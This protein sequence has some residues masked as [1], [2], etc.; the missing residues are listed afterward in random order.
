MKMKLNP[1]LR[2][3]LYY[4]AGI[5]LMKSAAL[6]TLPIVTAHLTPE[7]YGSLEILVTLADLGG[8]L[9]G[10]GMVEALFRFAG[11]AQDAAER[12]AVAASI[13]GMALT[14]AA[15]ALVATQATA[16][17][18]TSLLP[19]VGLETVQVRWLLLTLVLT[20]CIQ[21]PLAWLRMSDRAG[22]FFLATLAKT[23][24]QTCLVV[25]TVRSGYGVTGIVA[26]NA[27]ADILLATVL[28]CT[29]ARDSGLRFVGRG[30]LRYVTYSWPLIFSGLALF[31]VGSFDRWILAD[32]VSTREIAFY[33]L[34]CKFALI[35]A[36]LIRPFEMW[37]FPRRFQVLNAAQGLE[38]SARVASAGI[39]YIVLVTTSVAMFGP[40]LVLLLLPP[41]YHE[42]I[43]YLPWVTLAAGLQCATSLLTVGCYAGKTTL[44]PMGINIAGAAVAF[45]GYVV[46]IPRFGIMGA[47]AAT[48]CAQCLRLGL[49]HTLSQKAVF[50]PYPNARLLGLSFVA[51]VAVLVHPPEL[52]LHSLTSGLAVLLA[53]LT[54]S[55]SLRL[56]PSPRAALRRA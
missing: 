14:F 41:D 38:S 36:L 1:V 23:V 32:S 44:L 4:A 37:W 12:R 13:L 45:T 18:I 48:I 35:T 5:V 56:L 28:V 52:S 39:A 24:I 46:L 29:Q 47:I 42:A 19:A 17:W 54:A 55:V 51:V 20:S 31:V 10:L 26:S 25:F 33:G 22:A 30:T 11:A 7:Q 34:A 16:A 15:V 8:I 40:W 49:F 50:L 27:I 6:I 43:H 53:L 2:Q 21:I 3:G 9:L